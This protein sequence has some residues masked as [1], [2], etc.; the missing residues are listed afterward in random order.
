ME[1]FSRIQR[2]T[3]SPGAYTPQARARITQDDPWNPQSC[4]EAGVG[5]QHA[6]IDALG[7]R[8]PGQSES[9]RRSS[10]VEFAIGIGMDDGV[11]GARIY[12]SLTRSLEPHGAVPC[13]HFQNSSLSP[14]AFSQSHSLFPQTGAR[15]SHTAFLFPPPSL[16]PFP[17]PL[18]SC[19]L[20]AS[21]LCPLATPSES[22][23]TAMAQRSRTQPQNA[24]Q[25]ARRR[26]LSDPLAA[27]LL[28]PADETPDQR[29]ARLRQE[30]EAK[31]RSENI[32]KMLKHD[33]KSRRRK[34]TVKV[35]LL[36]QSESG[37]STTLK[38]ESRLPFLP[39]QPEAVSA[40]AYAYATASMVSPPSVLGPQPYKVYGEVR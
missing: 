29:E 17:L 24:Y 3:R 30:E 9:Q 21:S 19:P 27:A 13:T 1:R 36:G 28:P 40:C 10:G 15:V 14:I 33:E 20:P 4:D 34:K 32:D 23:L 11:A 8:V 5:E 35:L 26:S 7:R 37:K 31:K 6:S 25:H 18:P 2:S 38:R 39:V 22:A 12:H 16:S